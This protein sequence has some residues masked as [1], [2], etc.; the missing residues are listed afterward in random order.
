MV[1]KKF[2]YQKLTY[3]GFSTQQLFKASRRSSIDAINRALIY[4]AKKGYEGSVRFLLQSNAN[5]NTK[6]KHNF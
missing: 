4:D 1:A 3:P 5:V 2:M 6:D